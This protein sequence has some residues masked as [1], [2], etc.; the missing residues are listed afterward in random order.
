MT[1]IPLGQRKQS[2]ARAGFLSFII[3]YF[4]C[5]RCNTQLT[6]KLTTAPMVASTVV[7]RMSSVFTK[8]KA[9]SSVPLPVPMPNRKLLTFIALLPLAFYPAFHGLQHAQRQ[10]EVFGRQCNLTLASYTQN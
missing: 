4:R 6:A 8:A 1:V 10:G 5:H 7:F 3:D 9:L 2:P